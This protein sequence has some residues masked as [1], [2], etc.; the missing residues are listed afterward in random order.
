MTP[1]P[2]P[3]SGPIRIRN[4]RHG[5]PARPQPGN[6]PLTASAG[7]AGMRSELSYDRGTDGPPLRE[8]TIGEAFDDAA[9]R[10]PDQDAVVCVEQGVRWSYGE[11]SRRVD[12]VAG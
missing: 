12:L 9:R 2:W 11:L 4:R 7:E 1:T 3:R 10:W 8:V 5:L 6:D